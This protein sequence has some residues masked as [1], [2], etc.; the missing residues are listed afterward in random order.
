MD[1]YHSAASYKLSDTCY[2]LNCNLKPLTTWDE[3]RGYFF[4][5]S[6]DTQ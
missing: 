3:H 5:I 6:E 4:L 2:T 1:V